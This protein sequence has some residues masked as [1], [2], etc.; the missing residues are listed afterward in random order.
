MTSIEGHVRKIKEHLDEMDDAIDI[1]IENRSV[2]IGFHC[3]ACSI[4]MLE[5]YLHKANKI[6]AGKIVKH[7][8]FKIVHDGQKSEPLAERMINGDFPRKNEIFGLLRKIE[9]KRDKLAYGKSTGEEA[10]EVLEYFFKLKEIF[11]EELK[12]MG[13][14]I[15]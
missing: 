2:T 12:K 4:E 6:S 9:S 13:V 8:W 15:G 1:G 3:S 10:R 11:S 7:N 14:E 5:L